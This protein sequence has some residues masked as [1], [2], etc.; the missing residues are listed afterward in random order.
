MKITGSATPNVKL[1]VAA[2]AACIMCGSFALAQPTLPLPAPG[3]N[4]AAPAATPSDAAAKA[5]AAALAAKA[6]VDVS[7]AWTRA[8]ANGSTAPVYLH[9]VSAKDPDRLVGV[10]SAIAK[11]VELRDDLPQAAGRTVPMPAIDIPAGGTV[12]LGPGSR[13]LVLVGVKESLREGDTFLITLHFDKA[14]TENT[15]VK[16]LGSA[17]T[18]L[19]TAASARRGDTTASVSQR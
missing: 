19:P 12:N 4:P 2:A 1:W 16:I 3:T 11:S 13:Y 5:R 14:G 10:E 6:N 9:I 17:A 15:A 7:E 8:A 18:G